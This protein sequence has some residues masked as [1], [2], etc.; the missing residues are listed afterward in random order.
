MPPLEELFA[1]LANKNS[2]PKKGNI[3]GEYFPLFADDYDWTENARVYSTLQRLDRVSAEEAW[4][5]VLKSRGDHH[6]CQTFRGSRYAP[7][8]TASFENISV[9]EL[10]R[11]VSLR[12]LTYV[13]RITPPEPAARK[14]LLHDEWEMNW[15][16][17][18][19]FSN[20]EWWDQNHGLM[21]Y[22]RQI[23]LL[24]WL[25]TEAPGLATLSKADREVLV[26]K[27]RAEI[28]DLRKTRQGKVAESRF[29]NRRRTFSKE[30][31]ER[32]RKDYQRFGSK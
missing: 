15:R 7:I 32:I 31:A 19:L 18:R 10:F 30:D 25:I 16:P 9:Y 20:Q 13:L 12:N 17:I 26:S 2:E 24:E 23:Q 29:T 14:R 1:G 8:D 28:E 4:P 21:L 6:Y 5:F 3:M 11:D 22:E 27:A